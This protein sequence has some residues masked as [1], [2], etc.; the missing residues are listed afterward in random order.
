[1]AQ[2][3][4]TIN[5]APQRKAYLSGEI[6]LQELSKIAATLLKLTKRGLDED[7]I[8]ERDEIVYEFEALAADN[9]ANEDDFDCVMSRLYDWA[10]TRLDGDWNGKRV[11]WIAPS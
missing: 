9:S 3:Q 10:D 7:L 11:A 2:W 1:M 4:N 6:T 8:D 5:F